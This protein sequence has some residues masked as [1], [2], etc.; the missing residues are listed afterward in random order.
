[1]K[2]YLRLLAFVAGSVV[3]LLLL[4]YS[5]LPSQGRVSR[6]MAVNASPSVI[7][8]QIVQLRNYEKWFP[9]LV[10]DP[11]AKVQ[12]SQPSIGAGSYFTWDSR[13]KNLGSGKFEVTDTY[14][15]SLVKFRM[16]YKTIPEADGSLIIQKDLHHPYC[17]VLWQVQVEAGWKPWLRLFSLMMDKMVGPAL[18][19]GLTNLKIVSEQASPYDQ[20][21]ITEQTL[22]YVYI[23]TE[24]DTI[25]K[26][27][28][29]AHI[30]DTYSRLHKYISLRHLV[31]VGEPISQI[32]TLEN[33]SLQVNLGL[34][35]NRSAMPEQRIRILKMPQGL[36]LVAHYKGPYS[37]IAHAYRALSTYASE[38][39]KT[40][41]AP[42]WEGYM[43]GHF[44][45]D[46]SVHSVNIYLPVY[47]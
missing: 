29:K 33:G 44:P 28:L 13:L 47:R 16:L 18:E 36:V 32:D 1:M 3:L 39:A 37:G 40:S 23:A 4:L 10:A 17:I 20:Y 27:L 9:W 22:P 5:L 30:L 7:Y 6:E 46:D 35:V 21:R 19:N 34:P 12:Y 31:S 42:S 24:S 41:P 25:S 15:D 45:M 26:S 8:H 11:N 38:H 2:R 14:P 43:D